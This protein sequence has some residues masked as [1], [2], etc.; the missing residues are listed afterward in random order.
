MSYID[1]QNSALVRVK[2]TDVGRAQLAQGQ[3]SFD[4]WT[5][6]DSEVDYNYVKGWKQF[7]PSSNAAVGEFFFYGGDGSLTRNIYSKVLRPKDKQPKPTSYLLNPTQSP[8]WKT[9]INTQSSLQLLTGVVSNEA[10]DRGYF[11]GT[12]VDTGLIANENLVKETGTINLS[13]FIGET[14]NTPFIQGVLSGVTLTA[15]SED[16]FIMFRF[17]NSTLGSISGATMTAATVNQFYNITEISGTTIKV[18]RALP[19]L[20]GFAGTIITYYTFPGGNDPIDDYYGLPSLSSYWNTGTLA[21]DSDCDICVENIPVWNMNN[22]WSE[23]MAGQWTDTTNNYHSNVFFGSEQYAGTKQFLKYNNDNQTTSGIDEFV[24]GISIIHYTNECISNFYG[25]FFNIDAS[26]GKLLNLDIPIMWHR[27]NDGGTGSGTTLGMRFVTSDVTTSFITNT[28]IEYNPLVEFSGMSIDP[29]NLRTVGKV[30]PGLKIVVISDEELVA[31]MSYKSNRNYTLPD[32]SAE[33]VHCDPC[34]GCLLPG[35]RM[36][37]TYGLKIS[38]D[39]G[40]TTTL[41]CQ[42]YT[43]VQNNTTTGE[44]RNVTFSIASTNQLPYMRKIESP[45]YDGLGFYA[46]EFVL[47]AQSIDPTLQSRPL[48]DQWREINFTSTLITGVAGET[49]DPFLLEDQSVA[50]TG[51]L[52]TGD[53]YT[54]ATIYDLGVELDLPKGINYDKLNFGDERLFYGNLRTHIGATIYKTL[55]SI[56]VDGNQLQTSTNPTWQSGQD[57]F[58]TEIGILDASDNLVLVGK[59]SRPIRIG[60]T[61]IASIELTIDF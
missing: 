61:T 31:A 4:S 42:R 26:T 28:D 32:L 54:A 35:Q 14:D 29:N 53:L 17:S 39:T 38:G 23:N 37:L 49:I 21:F 25:E 52:L 41:P 50:N 56:T 27:R 36:Y 30:F 48:S 40:M 46:N 6:G 8:Q 12:T 18:D 13:A 44:D 11:S 22:V 2:L 7:L 34:T 5:A 60:A 3:L 24:K 47:L 33:H 51:F 57:R 16:D 55:F 45:G 19:V 9:S 1:K 58:V 59:L 20:S 10:Q 15:T 43:V